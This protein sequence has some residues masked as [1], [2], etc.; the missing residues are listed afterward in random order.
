MGT[1][2]TLDA[3]NMRGYE[4]WILFLMLAFYFFLQKE[5]YIW[6]HRYAALMN[7]GDD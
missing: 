6:W 1:V 4:E 3:A 2:S 7:V 5:A